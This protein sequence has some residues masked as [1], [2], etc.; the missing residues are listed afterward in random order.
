MI[1]F[2]FQVFGPPLTPRPETPVW[3]QM[4]IPIRQTH[5]DVG[6]TYRLSVYERKID[7]ATPHATDSDKRKTRQTTATTYLRT[8]PSKGHRTDL[9]SRSEDSSDRI[10]VHSLECD[11]VC[12]VRSV[13]GNRSQLPWYA[14]LSPT[15]TKIT[16]KD[17]PHSRIPRDDPRGRTAR[18]LIRTDPCSAKRSQEYF[19]R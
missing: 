8:S 11:W 17:R 19:F 1:G 15:H 2:A 9:D 7:K 3:A 12:L 6:H 14:H 4:F 16:L 5:T 10:A 13:F 18:F